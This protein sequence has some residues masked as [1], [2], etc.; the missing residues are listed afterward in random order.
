MSVCKNIKGFTRK[1]QWLA[2]L[3]ALLAV[4]IVPGPTKAAVTSTGAIAEGRMCLQ[5]MRKSDPPTALAALTMSD[6]RSFRNSARR[7][8]TY[9]LE[10]P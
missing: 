4:A 2:D 10:A 9:T 8:S 7:S 6:S 5:A 3:F 1:H